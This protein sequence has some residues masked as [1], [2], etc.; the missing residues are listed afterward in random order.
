MFNGAMGIPKDAP[1]EDIQFSLEED[2]EEEE[3]KP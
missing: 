2:D 3:V 1:I